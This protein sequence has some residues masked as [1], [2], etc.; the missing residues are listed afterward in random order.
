M[1]LHKYGI[2]YIDSKKGNAQFQYGKVRFQHGE[3]YGVNPAL[4]HLNDMGG[5]TIFGHTHKE[6]HARKTFGSGTDWISLGAGCLCKPPDYRDISTQSYGFISGWI[7]EEEGT[8]DAHHQRIY[9]ETIGKKVKAE[10]FTRE[11][12][13]MASEFDG[14]RQ[15]C[16]VRYVGR[17]RTNKET[18]IRQSEAATR[19][20]AAKS[21]KASLVSRKRKD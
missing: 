2:E 20:R 13:T 18:A 21:A 3:R 17:G 10:L 11:Y 9:V 12:G 8:F 15:K 6:S 16:V 7:D 4:L 19:P 5:H 1:G 14:K